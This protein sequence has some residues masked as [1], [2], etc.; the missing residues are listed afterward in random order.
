MKNFPASGLAGI[1]EGCGS[2]RG[3]VCVGGENRSPG[4]ESLCDPEVV[5][6][7]P[8][9][10]DQKLFASP[11]EPAAAETS[12]ERGPTTGPGAYAATVKK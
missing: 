6:L 5:A 2:S 3:I 4:A 1:V 11:G 9:T 8:H 7:D 12:L 10:D